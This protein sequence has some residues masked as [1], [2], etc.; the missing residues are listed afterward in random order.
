MLAN[1][2]ELRRLTTAGVL[3]I[4]VA[5]AGGCGGDD[6]GEKAPSPGG[7]APTPA[8]IGGGKTLQLKADASGQLRFDKKTLKADAGRVTLVMD[9]PAAVPHNVAIEGGGIDEE[10]AVVQQGGTS[11]VTATL[12]AGEY[13][14]YCSVPG[15]R[16]GGMVGTLTVR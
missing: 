6:D 15:H 1:P 11:R 4:A 14:F 2:H 9:N 3:A 13:E 16:E 12:K 8:P 7:G 5:V 10:G